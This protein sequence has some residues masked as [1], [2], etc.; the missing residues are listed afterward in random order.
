LGEIN[1]QRV[2]DR[3]QFL[4]IHNKHKD[5]KLSNEAKNYSSIHCQSHNEGILILPLIDE[6]AVEQQ[7][8]E[9]IA[10][11]GRKLFDKY[12]T[13]A[14][15]FKVP[16]HFL[17]N[18]AFNQGKCLSIN[19]NES[20]AVNEVAEESVAIHQEQDVMPV[21]DDV[22]IPV[23]VEFDQ[24]DDGFNQQDENEFQERKA[25]EVKDEILIKAREIIALFDEYV[26]F[27]ENR[28]YL[29]D[30]QKRMWIAKRKQQMIK[31]LL[32]E[33]LLDDA[34]VT[35]NVTRI[36]KAI[37]YLCYM[38]KFP[39]YQ[40]SKN[41]VLQFKNTALIPATG[42]LLES[43]PKHYIRNSI[44]FDFDKSADCPKWLAFLEQTF[45]KD[46]DYEDKVKLLQEFCGYSLTNDIS[47]QQSIM[48]FGAGSN[49]KSLILQVIAALVGEGNVSHVALK[50]FNNRFSL[51]KLNGKLVN[52]DADIDYDAMRSEGKF[53]S[54]VAGD[55]ITVE[56]KNQPAFSFKPCVKL[57]F[58]ANTLPKVRNNSHGYYRRFTILEFNH[59]VEKDKQNRNL[60]NELKAE[61]PGI[62]NWSLVG[63]QRLLTNNAFTIPVSSVE[64][65]KTYECEN[66]HTKHFFEEHLELISDINDRTK[67]QDIY[68]AFLAF[69]SEHNYSKTD[70]AKFGKELK[71]LGVT[72]SK[73]GSN[74][75]YHV[76]FKTEVTNAAAANDAEIL[77]ALSCA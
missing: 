60:I 24:H 36:L 58:A 41:N 7:T 66:N 27:T 52:I 46:A 8:P 30:Q 9:L 43:D 56:E 50:D 64:A 49:G 2:V 15:D 51:V 31:F 19:Q 63:L 57:W 65:V 76:K 44:D 74:R 68:R 73:S 1:E 48:L 39:V 12:Q 10:E 35:Q 42:E 69:L 14:S 5:A 3:T 21:L 62:L 13:G 45:G 37:E 70:A 4:A 20:V 61:L 6:M 71:A 40:G 11:W 29:C 32:T 16:V 18:A 75:Y 72:D 55:D 59:I 22:A 47:F 34:K 38:E 25:V 17:K 53:K 23:I 67:K 33:H 77:H 28:F 26:I 54:I